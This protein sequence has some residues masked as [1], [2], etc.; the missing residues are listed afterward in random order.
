M[1]E[2]KTML[3]NMQKEMKQQK[4]DMLEM[5]EDIKTTIIN[6]INDKFRSLEIK[7]DHLEKKLEEHSSAINNLERYMR[8][9]NLIIFGVEERE[10]SYHDLEKTILD[11]I[12]N[13]FN[14]QYENGIEAVRRL[15]KKGDKIRPVVVTFSTM[16]LKIKIQQNQKCLKNSPYYIKQDY[17][18]EVL[19]KR[20]ELQ[21]QLK[22]ERELGNKAFIKYD[23][24][25]V[26]PNKNKHLPQNNTNKRILSESPETVTINSQKTTEIKKQPI[27]K[28]KT[29]TMKNYILQKPKLVYNKES[30]SH[31]QVLSV[32]HDETE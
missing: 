7:S 26:L 15:G 10:K 20:R 1:E 22:E 25:V 9:K 13:Y 18:L 16:G 24:L 12:N 6:N 11:I 28:S 4:I 14:L 19:N 21:T 23:K 5:K 30:T 3:E 17:P 2:I 32:E 27:K 31:E 29:T 8:R